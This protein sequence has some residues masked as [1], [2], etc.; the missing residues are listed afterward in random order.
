MH[1]ASLCFLDLYAQ[2]ETK[3]HVPRVALQWQIPAGCFI[4][5]TRTQVIA[6][7]FTVHQGGNPAYNVNTASTNAG[8]AS[9]G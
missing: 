5:R 4:R 6:G 8:M 2:N 7:T 9:N 3:A 1:F